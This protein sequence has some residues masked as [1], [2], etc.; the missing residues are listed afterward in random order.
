MKRRH[1]A[2]RSPGT[3][4]ATEGAS[5]LPATELCVHECRTGTAAVVESPPWHEWGESSGCSYDGKLCNELFQVEETAQKRGGAPQAT[6]ADALSKSSVIGSG[7]LQTNLPT[8]DLLLQKEEFLERLVQRVRASCAGVPPEHSASACHSEQDADPGAVGH[9]EGSPLPRR[10]SPPGVELADGT[11]V[12]SSNV[13]QRSIG[14]PRS[15]SPSLMSASS[16]VK[17]SSSATAA[18]PASAQADALGDRR[19]RAAGSAT[20]Q[21]SR[22]P[23]PD[24]RPPSTDL[25]AMGGALRSSLQYGRC[26]GVSR[27]RRSLSAERPDHSDACAPLDT[28]MQ[29]AEGEVVNSFWGRATAASTGA[30]GAAACRSLSGIRSESV[31][32]QL[33]HPQWNP[34][35]V[36][37]TR[38]AWNQR[39][40]Q[41]KQRPVVSVPGSKPPLSARRCASRSP[42]ASTTAQ[43]L[44]SARSEERDA[45]GGSCRRAERALRRTDSLSLQLKQEQT[46]A[47]R[48][49]AGQSPGGTVTSPF[50]PPS[51]RALFQIHDVHSVAKTTSPLGKEQETALQTQCD[52]ALA[53][54]TQAERQCNILSHALEQLLADHAVEKV[55]WEVRHAALEQRLASITEWISGIDAEANL[56]A[57][58]QEAPIAQT[59][60]TATSDTTTPQMV[61]KRNEVGDTALLAATAAAKN[62]AWEEDADIVDLTNNSGAH[63]ADS[64]P[65]PGAPGATPT[66][67][68]HS[69]A[70]PDGGGASTCQVHL[71]PS[72][73][74]ILH[75]H[76]AATQ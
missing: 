68:R 13:G 72:P 38:P 16:T 1:S 36:Q 2:T 9:R 62:T 24:P 50:S 47:P 49:A 33:S 73:P 34:H 17:G 25:Y 11:G 43:G 54:A 6:P 12:R 26:S 27:G 30:P 52:A 4:A 23:S 74:L 37:V 58:P 53:R 20:H 67:A 51:A 57:A 63:S 32:N 15:R 46:T 69:N 3:F 10:L 75:M 42:E 65:L 28:Q 5:P 31:H 71:P 56:D 39:Q 8:G 35:P 76:A 40:P 61:T 22:A 18:E 60:E 55:A 48:R 7:A 59:P 64:S 29:E 19:V 44:R 14:L 70:N 66:P 21:R 41:R 45:T